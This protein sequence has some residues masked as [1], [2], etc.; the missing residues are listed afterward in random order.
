VVL[1]NSFTAHKF[2]DIVLSKAWS[3]AFQLFFS[4]FFF[5]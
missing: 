2:A 4:L 1:T 3:H 5:V